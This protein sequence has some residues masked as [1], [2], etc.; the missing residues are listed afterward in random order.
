M[1]TCDNRQCVWIVFFKLSVFMLVILFIIQFSC[2]SPQ[3]LPHEGAWNLVMTKQ[4]AED[5]VAYSLPG[6]MTGSDMKIW[7]DDHFIFVGQYQ[8]GTDT[9]VYNNWGGGTY[10]LEGTHYQEYIEYHV[11]ADWVGATPK[12]L[13]GIKGDTLIQVWPVDDNWQIDRSNYTIEKYVRF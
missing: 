4:I 13:L 11:N 9:T 10:T 2:T 3:I 7:A 1:K 12:M 5:T 6:D 8:W